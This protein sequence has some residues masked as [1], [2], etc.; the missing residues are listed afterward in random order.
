MR[1]FGF[2]EQLRKSREG[3]LLVALYLLNRPWVKD[4]A[5]L[6]TEQEA[7]SSGYDLMITR[8]NRVKQYVEVKAD[9]HDTGNVFLETEAN[10]KPG[11]F[12][13]SMAD[14]WVYYLTALDKALVFALHP[15]REEI[16]ERQEGDSY[17]KAQVH[18]KGRD[19]GYTAEGLIVPI[20]DLVASVDYCVEVDGFRGKCMEQAA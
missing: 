15:L 7:Q 11:C 4:V 12:L 6:D 9:S 1:S 10:E 19:G 3:V 14:V 17:R 13:S 8:E 18:T 2:H 5:V 20:K 16:M